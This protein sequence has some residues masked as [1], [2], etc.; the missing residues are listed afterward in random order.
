[1]KQTKSRMS[2]SIVAVLSTAVLF[3]ATLVAIP[4]YA[5]PVSVIVTGNFLSQKTNCDN[6][7][8]ECPDTEMENS[9]EQPEVYQ[10]TLTVPAG[11][12]EYK[13]KAD[14]NWYSNVGNSNM[15]ISVETDTEVT[16]QLDT[17]TGHVGLKLD[18]PE[19]PYS[20]DDDALI[21]TPV[22]NGTGENFY[23]VLTDRFNNGNIENDKAGLGDDR[24]KSGFD[25]TDKAFYHG[26]DIAGLRAKLDYIQDM[27]MTSLWLT[28]S[29]KNQPVQG[30]G[31]DASAGYHGYWITDFTQIDPHL[32]TNDELK[33]LID[34]AHARGIKVYFDII[35]NH[36]ADLVQFE[37]FENNGNVPYKSIAQFPYKDAQGNVFD[38]TEH[39]GKS[40]FPQL[41]A[42]TSFPYIPKRVGNIVPDELSDVTLYHNRGNGTWESGGEDFTFGDFYTL[43]DLMT[44]NPKVVTAMT[45]IYSTWANFGVDGFRID[46]AKHVNFPFWKQWTKSIKDNATNEKFFMFGEVYNFDA[47][48]LA[49]YAR[50]TDMDATLDFGWQNS[51]LDYLKGGSAQRLSGIYAADDLYTT[52]HSAAEDMPTFLGNHDMGRIGFLLRGKDNVLQREILG[53]E[54]MFLTRGQPVVYYGDEQGFVGSGADKDARQSLFATKVTEYQNQQL[55]DGTML[56]Q[57]DHYNQSAPV[58]TKIKNVAKLRKDY[59]ALNGGAQVELYADQGPG[60]YAFA[61]VDRTEKIEHIVAVNNTNENKTASFPTLTSNAHYEALYGTQTPVDSS[62]K[63][64]ITVPAFGAVVYRANK[65]IGGVDN[66]DM[67]LTPEKLQS[68][69][70]KPRALDGQPTVTSALAEVKA[71]VAAHRWTE[72]SF[73]WRVIGEDQ[74]HNLGVATGDKPRVFHDVDG[75]KPGTLVEYRAVSVD[76]T[77]EKVATSSYASVNLDQSE[78][79]AVEDNPLANRVFIPGT[80]NVA[81]GCSGIWKQDCPQAELKLDPASGWYTASY[82]LP[83]GEY[84]YKV[85]LN[86]KWDESYGEKGGVRGVSSVE[87]GQ[88]SHYSLGS[89]QKVTFFYNPDTHEFYNTAQRSSWTLPGSFN[90]ALGCTGGVNG[91][92]WDPACLVTLMAD[93]ENDGV[94]IYETLAIPAGDYAVKAVENFNWNNTNIGCPGHQNDNC[95]FTAQENKMTRFTLDTKNKTLTISAVDPTKYIEYQTHWLSPDTFAWPTQL[96]NDGTW[97]LYWASNGGIKFD[98]GISGFEGHVALTKDTR[99]LSTELKKMDPQLRDYTALHPEKPIENIEKVLTGQL[100]VVYKNPRG[101]PLYA[102]GV[103]I[104]RVLDALYADSAAKRSQGVSF[105]DGVP[106]LALWAPTAKTVKLRLFDEPG[107]NGVV[108]DKF[109]E[110]TMTRQDDGTWTITGKAEWKNRPYQYDV[111]VYVPEIATVSSQPDQKAKAETIQHN[112]VTDPNSVALAVNST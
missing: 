85:S 78:I 47:Q 91:G 103:Q 82:N 111:E 11:S 48:D 56:G 17:R 12:W 46:T 86:G 33:A 9:V 101:V 29:F 63:V 40:T 79:G 109:T 92:D 64:E 53:H 76:A 73:A 60:I 58:Y 39:A 110:H 72:T 81:M 106:S 98:D 100:V 3:C 18:R 14:E 37:G 2:K 44:E 57:G 71:N 89:D 62:D 8:K 61:R 28:P 54:L 1:M 95:P 97:E 67:T 77:G 75:I 80:H 34:D 43:D 22:R 70:A 88:N 93:P 20:S 112:I 35:V 7:A 38:I 69:Q 4:A 52:P 55:V 36:T 94:F 105:D 74:W 108:E 83:A 30:T 42:H 65:T 10:K 45:D 90:K 31:K 32:G 27:G 13:I 23:F 50:N 59:P 96:G 15:A 49:P 5:A 19:K 84:D 6:W 87:G 102:G 26:G 25:P 24:M 41:D 99:G 104:P 21:Q 16:F 68:V 51:A 66:S 107:K